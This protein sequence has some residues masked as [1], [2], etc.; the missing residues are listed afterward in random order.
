M[1]YDYADD[2]A[3]PD[4]SDFD[5]L[6]ELVRLTRQ[7][8][9]ALEELQEQVTAKEA[10]IKDLTERQLPDLMERMGLTK[11]T[12]R[13]GFKIELKEGV[14]ARMPKET[15]ARAIAWL[16]EHGYGDL[17][18]HDFKLSFKLAEKE[19]AQHAKQLLEESG[20]PF[21]EDPN[22]HHATLSS[23]AKEKLG[24]GEELPMDLFTV[25]ETKTVNIK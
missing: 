8:Q 23:F 16:D 7:E 19:S 5:E 1:S 2:Q 3:S 6:N 4:V 18:R 11:C 13:Q 25:I 12:T 21:R 17:V 14:I 9:I 22:V 24:K 10:R 20:L 15:K